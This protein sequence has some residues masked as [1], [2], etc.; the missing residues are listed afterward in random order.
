MKH[1]NTTGQTSSFHL[2]RPL[3]SS[4]SSSLA[5]KNSRPVINARAANAQIPPR[6]PARVIAV[7]IIPAATTPVKIDDNATAVGIPSRNAPMAPVHAPV[8]GSGIPTNAA[9]DAHCF[10]IDP[11]P[12]LADFFSARERIGFMSCLYAMIIPSIRWRIT[13]ICNL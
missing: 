8:P 6:F 2:N 1:K 9:R 12:R 5:A 4:F 13:R 7:I 10:S 11:T 3:S